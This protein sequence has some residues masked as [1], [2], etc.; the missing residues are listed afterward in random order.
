MR[1]KKVMQLCAVVMSGAMLLAGCGNGDSGADSN[2]QSGSTGDSQ[3]ASAVADDGSDS[4]AQ[5]SSTEP[6]ADGD[7][8]LVIGIQANTAV[9]SYDDNFLTKYLEDMTGIDLEFVLLP[10]DNN[11][12]LTKLSLLV[13]EP[14]DLPDVLISGAL[15][16]EVALDYGKNGIFLPVE[17]YLNDPSVMP[18]YNNIP[19]DDL[20]DIAKIMTL[21]DGHTYSFVKYERE[22]WNQTCNRMFINREWLD[23]LNLSVPTTTDELK[24][25]L[26]AFRDQDPNGNGIKDEIPLYGAQKVGYGGNIAKGLMN[27][28]T[29][30]NGPLALDENN[31]V[32]ASVIT[33][34]YRNG[35]RYMHD[36]YEE[37]LMAA[38]VF[39]DDGTQFKATLNQEPNVVGFVSAGSLSNWPDAKNNPNFLQMEMIAPV[40]GPEGINWSPYEANFAWQN[41]S[42]M[43]IFN[44]TDKVDL[45][46]KLADAFFD[47]TVSIMGRYGEKGVD[48]T[49]DPEV[50]K[51]ESNDYVEAGLYD[52]VKYKVLNDVWSSTTTDKFWFNA[53]PRYFSLDDANQ[54]ATVNEYSADDPSNLQGENVVL[55]NHLHPE[56]VL[57]TILHYNEEE[58]EQIQQA[59]IDIPTFVDQTMAEFITGSR[60]VENDWDAYVDEINSMGLPEWISC[61][62]SAYDRLAE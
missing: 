12:L 35:L 18:N 52:G 34:E 4:S 54:V 50:L 16:Q 28:F 5:A 25:V 55:Y 58:M 8:K 43:Y 45:A 39:T 21:A 42:V 38:T 3:Q 57:P 14:D 56:Y 49:D 31:K 10:S 53:G 26:I 59:L 24:E 11:D 23:K 30:F 62:Q 15:T 7:N 32:I 44:G 33:E 2:G 60:D 51:N 29:Y 41:H 47:P 22:T 40:A 37:G 48:W 20:E 13:S 17:D 6:A 19:K 61:A 27:S 36:L 9:S 1:K 46:V